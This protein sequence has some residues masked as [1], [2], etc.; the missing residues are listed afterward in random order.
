MT[1]SR[2]RLAD[3][4]VD[5]REDL[6][7]EIKNW[8]DLQDSNDDKAT[9]AKAVL[10]LV[11]HGGGFIILGLVETDAGMVEAEGRPATLDRYSQDLINGIVQNYCDPPFHCAVHIVANPTGA[12]FPIVIVPGGH[13][14]P[15][16]ARRAGP[17]GNTVQNNAIYIRK[18]GPR[19]ESPQSAQDWDDLLARCLRN[20]RD[21]MFDQIRD[22]ISGSVPQVEQPPEPARLDEWIMSSRERWRGLTEPLPERVG[23]RLPHG[24]FY[25]AYEIVGERRQIAPAQFPEL[26]RASV[27][28]HTGWPP[29]WYPTRAGIQP[30]LFDG[31]VECWLG[32]DPQTPV[33][34]RDAAHSDFW[35]IHPDGLAF[36]LRGFQEDGMDAQ[37]PGRAPIPPATVFDI[38]LPVWRVGEALLHARSL[39]AN[40]FE[41][42]TTIRFVANYEGLAGRSLASITNLRPVREGR[43]ARQDTITLNS[44]ID[45]QAIDPNL[46]E[47]VHPLLSPLYAL[48]D[49]FELPMQ[50]VVE[51]LANMRAGNF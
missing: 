24:R 35:R 33:E 18:P 31:A 21:E 1:V 9:F 38:T 27:T 6:D 50:L 42:P 10:A 48:F 8:L 2:E 19:S 12:V 28:R 40:L 5:P 23:P 26:L 37:L 49:F 17:N 46:P 51:E 14:V 11:N 45:A 32:G 20:R 43:V 7:C 13:R 4:L 44:H 25:V 15:V 34:A 30:Y 16:R 3:L 39:A 41:G 36:L 47:I 22:L 29:F